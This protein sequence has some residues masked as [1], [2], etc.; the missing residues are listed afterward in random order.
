YD[1]PLPD[2]HARADSAAI[3]RGEYLVY[4]PSHCVDCHAPKGEAADAESSGRRP[5]LIGGRRVDAPPLRAIYSEDPTPGRETGI[6]RYTD[7]QIARMLRYS[8]GPWEAFGRMS[9]EDLS[10]LYAFLHNLAPQ[11][12]PTGD[13]PFK[14]A[15]S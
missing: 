14:K 13:A 5:R 7:P 3:A 4:G 8:V 15:V 12:G 9:D 2:L 10:A 11:H 1:A 6:G